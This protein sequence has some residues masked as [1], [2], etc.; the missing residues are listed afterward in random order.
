MIAATVGGNLGALCAAA[1]LRG[2]LDWVILSETRTARAVLAVNASS[3]GGW[4]REGGAGSG[5]DMGRYRK[6]RSAKSAKNQVHNN[7]VNGRLDDHDSGN[8]DEKDH[9]ISD[10]Q[11][12]D[13]ERTGNQELQHDYISYSTAVVPVA[14]AA[15]TSVL[16]VVVGPCSAVAASCSFAA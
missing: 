12:V 10:F 3:G 9:Y 6:R 7:F 11:Y 4:Q 5:S 16:T 2:D 14:A 8:T 15:L 13:Q 1:T